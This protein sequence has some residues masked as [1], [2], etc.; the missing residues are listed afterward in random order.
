[1]EISPEVCVLCC[2]SVQYKPI[3]YRCRRPD[4]DCSVH[5]VSH[6]WSQ[7]AAQTALMFSEKQ[8]QDKICQLTLL[9]L[10]KPEILQFNLD[11]NICLAGF[12]NEKEQILE[13]GAVPRRGVSTAAET[14]SLTHGQGAAG[15]MLDEG[16][17]RT[18]SI[19]PKL[20]RDSHP[21]LSPETS[22][23]PISPPPLPSRPSCL[24]TWGA[25]CAA[26]NPSS[27]TTRHLL[28]ESL[29]ILHCQSLAA[30]VE[31]LRLLPAQF[32]DGQLIAGAAGRGAPTSPS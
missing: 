26:E 7:S 25:T 15:L 28:G 4:T 9:A 11:S 5:W 3:G 2:T 12:L 6:S 14:T 13:G 20:R 31:S 29:T 24:E 27:S 10:I 19:Y 22:S 8:T 1:M 23:S 16:K 18:K 32:P 30:E 17:Q 21:P